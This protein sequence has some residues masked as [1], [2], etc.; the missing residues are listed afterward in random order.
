M[1][2]RS[3][4]KPG[5]IQQFIRYLSLE[6]NASPH[7]CRC[8]RKDLE[9][10]EDFL[11]GSGMYVSPSGSVEIEK[12]DRMAIRKYMS[13]L[14]RKNKKS[15]IARKI[16][17]LRSFFKYLTREQVIACNPAKSVSTP[18]VEK[19]LPTTLT[20]DE[21]F[22]LMESPKS[23]PEKSS[24]ASKENRS[25]D[26]AILELLYSSGLRVSELVGLNLDQLNSDLGIV[27]VMG[28]GR[29]ERIVPV[30]MKALEALKIYLEERGVLR[31]EDPIFINSFG[32][33]LTTRSVGRLIKKYT[34]HSGI[35]RKVSPHSLRHTFATHLL[36]AGADIREIQEMLGHASLSTTQKYTHV[37]MGRLM[38]VYDKAHPRS[39][40][41]TRAEKKP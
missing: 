17:T 11:K 25:R 6:K 23:L 28:K 26:R 33:R 9:G 18:K 37:S 38:E 13:F 20:V 14:H 31:G 22:R 21:A 19:T 41:N 39:F 5:F 36:D 8:Y 16:S 29:K 12:A 24:E 40:G 35:F 27:R 4:G 1:V 7:T 34:R 10:F 15:S 3:F 32:G 2:S 30:G